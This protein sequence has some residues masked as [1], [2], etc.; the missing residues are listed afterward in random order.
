MAS[1]GSAPYQVP[2]V[3]EVG[4]AYETRCYTG[5]LTSHCP[6][7]NDLRSFH[8]QHF[9]HAACLNRFFYNVPGELDAVDETK[10]YPDGTECT[11]DESQIAIFRHSEIQALLKKRRLAAELEAEAG[12]HPVEARERDS[13]AK[14]GRLESPMLIAHVAEPGE[15]VK[16]KNKS[17]KRK[18]TAD[19]YRNRSGDW[20]FRR[21]AR[22]QDEQQTK[23]IELDY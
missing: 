12:D 4:S 8:A 11:L 22:E 19:E 13:S 18:W 23:Q 9:P 15:E 20:T 16:K 3:T 2:E 7:Q 5:L 14:E 6:S 10:Y 21:R 17:K 1:D